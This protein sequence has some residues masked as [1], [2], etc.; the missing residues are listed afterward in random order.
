M[1]CLLPALACNATST[2]AP[3]DDTGGLDDPAVL[4]MDP[5]PPPGTGVWDGALFT[6][7]GRLYSIRDGE[8]GTPI[9]LTTAAVGWLHE[10]TPRVDHDLLQVSSSGCWTAL[11]SASSLEYVDFGPSI[12]LDV[13]GDALT[14][15]L[16]DGGDTY[17][18]E[19][20][21]LPEGG[22]LTFDGMVSTA[23][24]PE[25][26]VLVDGEGM[27]TAYAATGTLDL[28]WEPP[29][30]AGS[31]MLLYRDEADGRTTGCVFRDDGAVT[32]QFGA[33]TEGEAL[34]G[35]ILRR[36]FIDEL[37]TDTYGR[38]SVRAQDQTTLRAL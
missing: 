13:G 35:F 23:V 37:E 6:S 36:S 11:W 10:P 25:P 33:P 34:E 8:V 29:S 27:W 24:V 30:S 3:A 14:L 19:G 21:T 28:A 2:D 12:A 32:I 1:L 18:W 9:S 5:G 4:P 31:R 15:D 20:D 26:V 16:D 22:T 17:K 7:T 38:I